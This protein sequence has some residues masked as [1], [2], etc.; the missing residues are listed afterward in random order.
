[1]IDY[2]LFFPGARGPE[3]SKVF[4]ISQRTLA[5]GERLDV[6]GSH[7]FREITTRQ[8][9]PGGHGI[10]LQVNGVVYGRGDFVLAAAP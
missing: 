3:R 7:A 1:M 6:E 8:Y 4:K 2:V 10:A 9:Y 5:P